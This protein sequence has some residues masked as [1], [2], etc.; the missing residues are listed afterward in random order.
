M[1]LDFALTQN[2][3]NFGAMCVSRLALTIPGPMSS[4]IGEIED[5]FSSNGGDAKPGNRL[6]LAFGSICVIAISC[7]TSVTHK[8]FDRFL[9]NVVFSGISAVILGAMLYSYKVPSCMLQKSGH[10]KRKS[11]ELK[12]ILEKFF[13][14]LAGFYAIGMPVLG[15]IDVGGCN[16]FSHLKIHGGSNHPLLPAGLLQEWFASRSPMDPSL[17]QLADFAGGIIRIEFSSSKFLN[18]NYP[19]EVKNIEP[20]PEFREMLRDMGHVA[21]MFS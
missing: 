8:S 16:M 12:I 14:V 21:R 17:G 11:S 10:S 19:N 6:K 3:A 18:S 15:L 4:I 2:T 13:I 5:G 9:D 7:L 1:A 20:E